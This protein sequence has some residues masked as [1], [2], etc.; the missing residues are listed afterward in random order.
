MKAC[1]Y[2]YKKEVRELMYY[3]EDRV[4]Y[5]EPDEEVEYSKS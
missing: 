3:D 4:P 1:T 2:D 5:E